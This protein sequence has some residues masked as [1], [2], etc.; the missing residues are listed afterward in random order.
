[1]II[2]RK[3]EVSP[4]TPFNRDILAQDG[5]NK[6]QL[7]FSNPILV[8]AEELK[9]LVQATGARWV[10]S[11]SLFSRQHTSKCILDADSD[12]TKEDYNGKLQTTLF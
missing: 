4:I 7:S 6:T 2:C 11:P 9:T 10:K 12:L 8:T 1:M 5:L 3:S